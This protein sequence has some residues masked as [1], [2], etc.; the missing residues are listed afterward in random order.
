MTATLTCGPTSFPGGAGLEDRAVQLVRHPQCREA[1]R[2]RPYP[3]AVRGE[4]PLGRRTAL[5]GRADE[6]VL[7]VLVLAHPLAVRLV[8]GRPGG[9]V[10]IAAGRGA[11][12]GGARPAVLCAAGQLR[13]EA[14]AVRVALLDNGAVGVVTTPPAEQA[15]VLPQGRHAVPVD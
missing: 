5:P 3:G 15:G 1:G 9:E 10:V 8:R 13:R 7:L 4:E 12:D 11:G 6:A 14:P 2:R